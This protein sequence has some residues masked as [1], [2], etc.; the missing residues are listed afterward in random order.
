[1]RRKY[2]DSKK[3]ANKA[4]CSRAKLGE[5]NLH[6]FKMPKGT[7]KAGKFI[8]CTEIEFLNTY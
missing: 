5:L 1:M 6:V 2:F 3:E 4:R 8:L 7:R